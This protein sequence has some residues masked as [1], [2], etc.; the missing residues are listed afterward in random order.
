MSD[1]AEKMVLIDSNGE[2]IALV[3]DLRLI[4]GNNVNDIGNTVEFKTSFPLQ[5]PTGEPTEP[6][7]NI[8]NKK[9]CLI[10]LATK[11]YNII[12]QFKIKIK[13][14]KQNIPNNVYE[15]NSC[16]FVG[17][18]TETNYIELNNEEAL[19]KYLKQR[20]IFENL[21]VFIQ[22]TEEDY[23]GNINTYE[24]NEI[25]LTGETL[26]DWEWVNDWYEGQ[27]HKILGFIEVN[28]LKLDM[29]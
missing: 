21:I 18:I 7:K 15:M 10:E 28:E 29:C 3:I 17:V 12:K 1:I 26:G 19:M 2:Q 9:E 25:L 16:Y 11:T 6:F 24:H 20:N 4:D 13:T 5:Y 8:F 27:E 14:Y 22:D 23:D